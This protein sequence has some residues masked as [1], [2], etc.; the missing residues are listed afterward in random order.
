MKVKAALF[1]LMIFSFSI[2]YPAQSKKNNEF[3]EAIWKHLLRSDTSRYPQ[4]ENIKIINNLLQDS[5]VDI[6]TQTDDGNTAVMLASM[7]HDYDLIELLLKHKADVNKVNKLGA[8]A[9]TKLL[10]HCGYKKKVVRQT[11]ESLLLLLDKD[12]IV[13]DF[14][15][16]YIPSSADKKILKW[17]NWYRKEYT[18]YKQKYLKLCE[19][20]LNKVFQGIAG[21]ANHTLVY[22][23]DFKFSDFLEIK[24]KEERLKQSQSNC[25]RCAIL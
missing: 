25:Y 19:D 16:K 5:E 23:N 24:E 13:T 1:Y 14:D 12:I 15:M 8:S 7:C 21:L 22:C 4:Y 2:C 20:N 9:I 18:P 11:L 10:V 17:L 3:L 6:N